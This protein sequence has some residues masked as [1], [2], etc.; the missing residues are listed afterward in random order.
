VQPIIK[1]FGPVGSLEITVRYKITSDNIPAGTSFLTVTSGEPRK[2]IFLIHS[3]M[4]K[5]YQ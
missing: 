2:T 3:C 4:K 1:K 5:R